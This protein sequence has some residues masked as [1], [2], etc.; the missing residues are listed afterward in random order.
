[1]RKFTLVAIAILLNFNMIAQ[2]MPL[3]LNGFE[4]GY[5]NYFKMDRELLFVHL[6]KTKILPKENLWFSVYVGSSKTGLPNLE[7]ANLMVDVLDS[8]GIVKASQTILITSGK[9]S[10][11]IDINPSKFNPGTYYIRAHTNYMRNFKEDHSY[12]QAF[13]ILGDN[14]NMLKNSTSNDLQILPEGGHLVQG[15]RNSVGVKL[16]DHNGKGLIF[17]NG[18]VINSK[19]EVITQF[20]SNQFGL[21]KFSLVPNSNESY[22]IGVTTSEGKE[23]KLN[24]PKAQIAGYTVTGNNI[25]DYIMFSFNTNELSLV[26]NNKFFI[27]IHQAGKIK[28]FALEFPADKKS[29]EM[30]WNKD[31]LF[32]GVNTVTV[33]DENFHPLVERQFFNE[34]NLKRM[35]INGSLLRKEGDS[36]QLALST[37]QKIQNNSLSIS[38]LPGKSKSYESNHSLLSAF[39]LKPFLKGSIENGDYYFSD[40]NPRKTS[41]DLDLLMLT[42]GWSKYEWNDIYNNIPQKNYV[43]ELGFEIRGTI[44]GR[45]DKKE[46]SLYIKSE[47]T[48]LFEIVEIKDN[49]QF[50][51]PNTYVV[52]STVLSFGLMNDRN[53][54]ISKP[55]IVANIYPLK[56]QVKKDNFIPD[57][58]YDTKTENKIPENF[59]GD[60]ERLDTII[61]IGENKKKDKYL[62][63]LRVIKPE[64]T[65]TEDIEKRYSLITDYIAANGFRVYTGG[66]GNLVIENK[67][68]SSISPGSSPIPQIYF[69]GMRLGTDSSLLVNLLTSE[70]ESIIISTSGN[71]Y[72][73]N[74]S[75]G[76]IEI[77][78]RRGRSNVSSRETISEII[79]KNGFS[80]NQEFYSPKYT[81]YSSDY[82]EEYG[83]IDWISNLSLG[84]NG[85]ASFNILNTLQPNIKLIIEGISKDGN[86]ISEEI[87]VKM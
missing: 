46:N 31:S 82:F 54:K 3:D 65:I 33:F 76:V 17:T 56:N 55:S 60:S 52:D 23:E 58:F 57:F 18:R 14:S 39:Y 34:K 38:V 73:M 22:K 1:M 53:S 80:T 61:L 63:D 84:Q 19:N 86:L 21:S 87:N 70:V 41:Y 69:N 47:E 2:F 74:G 77:K 28:D 24:L 12:L 50:L 20:K 78:T 36:I 48:G 75:N 79:T 64:I 6:N 37:N 4:S 26:K 11:F 15:I 40:S 5:T 44:N 10:G 25:G 67:S 29:V 85:N 51:L 72:G 83:V 32:A 27:A 8:S 66:Y 59:I 62:N 7:T 71:G 45:N 81:S 30:K 42:Q 16:L 49:N 9:G 13:S 68:P 35:R 43:R